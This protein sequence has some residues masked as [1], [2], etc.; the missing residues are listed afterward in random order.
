MEYKENGIEFLTGQT[1]A[2][3]SFSNRKHINRIKKLYEKHKDDFE[4]FYENKDGSV[5]AKI[6]LKWVKIS[7]I[8]NVNKNYTDEQKKEI[9][10][11]FKRA[12]ESKRRIGGNK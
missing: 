8:R 6:P 9:S 11:R 10:E 2:T 3:V 5:C 7:P 4:Y 1:T 12:R